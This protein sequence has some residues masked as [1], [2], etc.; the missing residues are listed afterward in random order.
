M[1]F[2][3]IFHEL[4]KLQSFEQLNYISTYVTSYTRINKQN[5]LLW[6]TRKLLEFFVNVILFYDEEGSFR[7]KLLL[8]LQVQ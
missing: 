1:L 2:L 3:T 5:M 7:Q 8:W 4:V 6:L